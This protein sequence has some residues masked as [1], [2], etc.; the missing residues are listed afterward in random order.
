V[1]EVE[2]LAVLHLRLIVALVVAEGIGYPVVGADLLAVEGYRAGQPQGVVA[3][4]DFGHP[5]VEVVVVVVVAVDH[6]LERL[7]LAVVVEV[8]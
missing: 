4:V 3:Q 1:F 6:P 5:K 2:G 8:G 7:L